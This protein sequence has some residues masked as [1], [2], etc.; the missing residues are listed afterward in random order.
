MLGCGFCR[1]SSSFLASVSGVFINKSSLLPFVFL[2][3][4]GP[5]FVFFFFVLKL[6][7]VSSKMNNS[8]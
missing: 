6:N 2:C 1:M 3:T 4:A 8:K 5:K 7:V